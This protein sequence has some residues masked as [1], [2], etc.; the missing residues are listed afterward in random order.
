[1][2]LDQ[3]IKFAY[4]K[5]KDIWCL[6]NKGKS[7]DNSPFPTKVYEKLVDEVGDNPSEETTSIFIDKY[8]FENKYNIA[9]IIK[10][11][12]IDSD[13]AF[14]IFIKRAE[15]IFGLKL[16]KEV[17]AYLTINNR[18]PYNIGENYFFVRISRESP[19][20]TV[21]HELWH[22]YTWYKFGITDETVL[23]KQKYND[24][25]EALTVLLNVEFPDLLNGKKDFGYP[26]H[27][28]L[29][30]KILALWQEKPDIEFVWKSL[31]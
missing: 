21:M 29:R 4:D 7:S 30:A 17:T 22:F 1:M 3:K 8:L 26:Q 6:L 23:G 31:I 9:E 28:E 16:E 14:E 12:E 2:E 27:Q 15:E 5:S 24:L 25:K 11:Y 10:Q 18:C 19:T 13:K 20:S